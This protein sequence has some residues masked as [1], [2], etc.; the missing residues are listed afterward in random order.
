[1]GLIFTPKLSWSKAKRKLAAQARKASFCIRNYQRKFGYF[2]HEEIFRL[3]D[4]MVKPILCFGSEIWGYEYSDVIESVHNEFCRYFLGVNSSVNNVVALGECGRLPLC[5][6]YITNCIKYWCKLLCMGNHR[7]P[8][9]CYKM[10]KSLDEAGRHTWAANVS[11]LLYTYGFGFA[12]ISQEIGNENIFVSQFKVRLTDCMKQNWHSD[13][14]ESPRCDSYKEFKTLLNVER[15]LSMDMQFYLRKAFARFRTSSHK[16]SIEIGRH[17]NINRADRI[18]IFCFNQHNT[19]TIEDEYHAFF[20][21]PK[22]DALRETYL[23]PWYR[24]GDSRPEFFRLM[25]ETKP[26]IIKKLCVFINEILNIKDFE[27]AR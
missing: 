25:Q 2:K 15:Y 18:C 1:M 24:Q 12:W 7:Y 26:D 22:F 4:A 17:H 21:C 5:V 13:I 16:L 19:I 11:S 23:I 20:I 10:L 27:Y 3:F 8:K 9:N 6:T 14:N